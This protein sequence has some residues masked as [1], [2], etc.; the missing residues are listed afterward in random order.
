MMRRW[1]LNEQASKFFWRVEVNDVSDVDV[2]INDNRLIISINGEEQ[3]IE[4]PK[5]CDGASEDNI[6]ASYK[7]KRRILTITV[8][9]MVSPKRLHSLPISP[10]TTL[11]PPAPASDPAPAA[12]QAPA[13]HS[14]RRKKEVSTKMSG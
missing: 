5:E 9:V 13:S 2:S 11:P 1:A 3:S 7:K 14:G 8:D 12:S 4:L 6:F 10:S